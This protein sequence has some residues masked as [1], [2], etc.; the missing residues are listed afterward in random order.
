MDMKNFIYFY[1]GEIHPLTK[2][3]VVAVTVA[4][5]AS[6]REKMDGKFQVEL[7]FFG[8]LLCHNCRKSSTFCGICEMTVTKKT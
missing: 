5:F 2:F 3:E 1:C 6:F 4:I 7:T 8:K